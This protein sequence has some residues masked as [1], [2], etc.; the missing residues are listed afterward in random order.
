MPNWTA[1]EL[2]AQCAAGNPTPEAFFEVIYE[3][4]GIKL[5]GRDTRDLRMRCPNGHDVTG[6]VAAIPRPQGTPA[7]AKP[8]QIRKPT[9]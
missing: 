4:P 2:C 1:Q 9:N 7:E 3:V 5:F 6:Q 8:R